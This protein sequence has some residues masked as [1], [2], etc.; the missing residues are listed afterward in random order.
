MFFLHFATVRVLYFPK[1]QGE[2]YNMKRI[3]P[4]VT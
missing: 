1:Q 4:F 2:V 3:F